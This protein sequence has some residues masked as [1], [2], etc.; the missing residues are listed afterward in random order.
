MTVSYQRPM[1]FFFHAVAVAALAGGSALAIAA[2]QAAPQST[3]TGL[4][5]ALNAVSGGPHAGYRANHAKGVVVTGSFT[6]APTA[7]TLSKAPHFLRT[8]PVIV[9]FSDTTG[10]PAIP[11]ASPDASP[12]GMAIR[13]QLPANA[14]TDIVSISANSFPVATPGDFQALLEAVAKSGPGVAKPTPIEQFLG[15]H[16]AA[17][18]FVTTPRPAPPSFATLA[19][20]GVNAFQFTNATGESH[21]IRYQIIPLAGEHGLTDDEAGKTTANYLM[22]ELPVRIARGPVKFRLMAQVANAD[23]AINDATV[24]WPADRKLVELGT[25]TLT[26]MAP[27][28]AQT[29]KKLLF[30]PVS[31]PNGIAPSADPVLLAR[32]PS[33]AVSF[34][35]RAQ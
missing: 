34:R 25:L 4:V 30:N 23:D 7:R 32:F 3:P 31:L 6:P 10:V 19:F 12:H 33:Y 29:Q 35:Q 1:R 16:P 2:D 20:Y 11:D 24:T 13:F 28:Q 8:V 14:S 18:K 22:D 9:R 15:S 27:D 17:L 5:D 21:F 26:T